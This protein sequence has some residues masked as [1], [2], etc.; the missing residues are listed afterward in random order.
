[1]YTASKAIATQKSKPINQGNGQDIR[2]RNPEQK[3]PRFNVTRTAARGGRVGGR[4]YEL[5]S[6]HA[7]PVHP[8]HHVR[9]SPCPLRCVRACTDGWWHRARM[10][11]LVVI[12]LT[13]FGRVRSR[14]VAVGARGEWL[15]SR[16]IDIFLFQEIESGV[17]Y[18][19]FMD[20][21]VHLLYYLKSLL[22]PIPLSPHDYVW[23][24]YL[25]SDTMFY[26]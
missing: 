23:Y 24:V 10:W 7:A 1:M 26:P 25:L 12:S 4:A 19:C 3:L 17:Y 13:F 14:D 22:L 6:P 9:T 16:L 11:C 20:S 5:N 2:W 18:S 21:A 8:P 15:P